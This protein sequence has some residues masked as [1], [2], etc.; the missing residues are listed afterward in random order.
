MKKRLLMV[1]AVVFVA[2]SLSACV[3]EVLG[4][5]AGTVVGVAEAGIK[6]VSSVV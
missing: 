6:T 1:C 4:A 2:L 3:G 5:A